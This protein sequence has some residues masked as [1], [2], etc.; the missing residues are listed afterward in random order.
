MIKNDINKNITLDAYVYG[1]YKKITFNLKGDYK[2]IESEIV[3]N[4]DIYRKPYYYEIIERKSSNETLE[5]LWKRGI[6]ENHPII[7]LV[8][9]N[10]EEELIFDRF[11]LKR[12]RN[13]FRDILNVQNNYYLRFGIQIRGGGCSFEFV[14]FDNGKTKRLT[15]SKNAPKWRMVTE[16][17]NLFG[18]CIN[19]NCVAFNKE[20]VDSKSN[21]I[22]WTK[23]GN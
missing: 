17:L 6:K 11:F 8:I 22:K 21:N 5:D 20:V 13:F 18:L 4:I 10:E 3:S 19:R 1:E 2:T 12:K 15:F 7:F 16:G 23:R 9:K 14:D